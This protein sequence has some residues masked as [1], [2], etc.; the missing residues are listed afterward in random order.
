MTLVTDN[1]R[2]VNLA[3]SDSFGLQGSYATTSKLN[4]INMPKV[5]DFTFKKVSNQGSIFFDRE[6]PE[7]L[8]TLKGILKDTSS[9]NTYIA[10]LKKLITDRD[11][12]GR[13]KEVYLDIKEIGETSYKRY[14]GQIV[15]TDGL[16]EQEHYHK[17]FLPFELQFWCSVPY[18][19]DTTDT[20]TNLASGSGLTRTVDVTNSG[21]DIAFPTITVTVTA[22]SNLTKLTLTNNTMTSRN[23][24]ELSSAIVATDVLYFYN[25]TKKAKLNSN[26]VDPIGYYFPLLRGSNTIQFAF[27]GTSVTFS[28]SVVHRNA[29]L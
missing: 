20:T 29:Y 8:I 28:A 4:S 5:D 2:I 13:I 6:F 18:G 1:I 16:F 19:K 27:T 14:Q 23:S 22:D 11:G 17:T 3:E 9:L 26:Y 25:E 10:N 24:I 12:A 15:N 21:D 7:K